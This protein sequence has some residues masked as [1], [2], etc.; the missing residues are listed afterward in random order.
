MSVYTVHEPPLRAAGAP[1]DP[2]RFAFVRDGFSGWAFVVAP[3]WMLVHRMWLVFAVYV[4]GA[5]GLETLVRMFGGSAAAVALIGL[6]IA[7]AIGLEAGSLRRFT[8]SRRGWK[9]VGIVSGRD[10]EQAEQRFFD[11]WASKVA[12][13]QGPRTAAAPAGPGSVVP[14]SSVAHSDVIGLFP[15]PGGQ[16]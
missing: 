15:E 2:E 1:P 4:V 13:G 10:R 11:A 16:R 6:L 7:L 9:Q 8:L 3:L 14:S 5:A 12:A